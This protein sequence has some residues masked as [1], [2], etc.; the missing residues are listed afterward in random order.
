MDEQVM[1]A[2]VNQVFALYVE[3]VPEHIVP[4]LT[5]DSYCCH[6]MGSVVQ[7]IQELGV[8]VQHIPGSWLHIPLPAHCRWL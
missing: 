3:M 2:W 1:L 8:E 6:V 5:L 4:L 7:W